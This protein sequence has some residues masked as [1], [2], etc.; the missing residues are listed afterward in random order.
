MAAL[1]LTNYVLTPPSVSLLHL[2]PQTA[3]QAHVV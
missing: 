2:P 1:V 3:P